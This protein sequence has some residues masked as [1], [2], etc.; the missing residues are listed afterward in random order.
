MNIFASVLTYTLGKRLGIRGAARALSQQLCDPTLDEDGLLPVAR[1]CRRLREFGD[2]IVYHGAGTMLP[3]ARSRAAYEFL[4]SPAD[5]WVMCDDDVETDNDTWQRLL[6]IAGAWRVAVLRCAIRGP[7]LSAAALNI[8]WESSL[9]VLQDG[10][11]T[12]S[13][14]R[15]GCGLMVVPRAALQRV[16]EQGGD[17][18][19]FVDDD[20]ATKLALFQPRLQAAGEWLGED[21]SFC[22][23][24]RAADVRSVA[25]LEGTSWHDAALIDL[26]DCAP[27]SLDA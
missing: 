5:V 14:A 19:E 26:A 27:P 23:R 20:G 7:H 3:K 24:L 8:V 25:P 10:V 1:V 17:A 22:E 13:V 4:R 21:Y 15:G 6:T 16:V 9:V 12:R 11:Q 2:V 18:L